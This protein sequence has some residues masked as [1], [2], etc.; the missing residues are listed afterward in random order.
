MSPGE[1][2]SELKLAEEMKPTSKLCEQFQ[3]YQDKVQ[4]NL[5]NYYNKPLS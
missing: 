3:K 4:T 2:E 5:V 1:L